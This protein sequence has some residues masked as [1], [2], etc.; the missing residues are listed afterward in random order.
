[1]LTSEVKIIKASTW[2]ERLWTLDM[3]KMVSEKKSKSNFSKKDF[4]KLYN[5]MNILLHVPLGG[6]TMQMISTSQ[7]TEKPYN[8]VYNWKITG[9]C[10]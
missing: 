10:V 9:R 1:M 2:R 3:R 4:E 7:V 6:G 5:D 8:G